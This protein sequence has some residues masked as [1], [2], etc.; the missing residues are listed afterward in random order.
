MKKIQAKSERG[1]QSKDMLKSLGDA[2]EHQMQGFLQDSNP[3]SSSKLG[4]DDDDVRNV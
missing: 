4:D 2:R 3:F 1:K